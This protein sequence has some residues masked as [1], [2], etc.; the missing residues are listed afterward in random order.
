M[1]AS[2]WMVTFGGKGK[3]SILKHTTAHV[4]PGA[5]PK[6][7]C[8]ELIDIFENAAFETENPRLWCDQTG[9]DSR[10]WC[11]EK[12]IGS[13]IEFFDIDHWVDA[14]ESYTGRK[15][16]S[17]CLMANRV[18]HADGNLGSGGGA[19][20]DSAFSHQVKCIWYLSDVGPDN[21]PF[22]YI[23][24]TNMNLWSQR[25]RYPL[26]QTRLH[27]IQEGF[28]EVNASAGTM[29]ACDTK[30]IHRGKPIDK[31]VRYAV[32][33]Y[34]FQSDRGVSNILRKSGLIPFE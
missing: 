20:R 26:G 7:T 12:D 30:C 8:K 25:K 21:G 3:L 29:L 18:V 27:D 28:Q 11:F 4:Y 31:G 5:L 17:W 16:R 23:P 22:Q 32:T 13:L 10:L 34:T 6:H 1:I 2:L 24:E 9:S 14:V 19:H 33:L 15:V